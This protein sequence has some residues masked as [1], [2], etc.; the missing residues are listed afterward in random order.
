MN[1]L[2]GN[3]LASPS[4]I[5]AARRKFS[6]LAAWHSRQ[7]ER[8]WFRRRTDE[9]PLGAPEF[10]SLADLGSAFAVARRMRLFP[11]DRRSLLCFAAAALAPLPILLIMD[12]K[13]VAFLKHIHEGL[14]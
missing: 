3:A 9:K 10:S 13:F 1:R 11:W 14:L 2:W 6:A 12:R 5:S 4:T 7:F 8:K